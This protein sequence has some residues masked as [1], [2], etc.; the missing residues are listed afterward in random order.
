MAG[1]AEKVRA[2]PRHSQIAQ[3]LGTEIRSGIWPVGGTLPAEPEL[4][5]R[6]DVSRMTVRQ[7]LGTLAEQGL[8]I[9]QRGRPTRIAYE[10]F[11]QPLGRFYSFAYEV[12][13]QGQVHS[14]RVLERGLT[15]PTALLREAFGMGN[16]EQVAQLSLLRLLGDEPLM[17]ET[18]NFRATLLPLIDRSDVTERA[19]YDILDEAGVVVTR[20]SERIWPI[21]LTSAQ[22]RLLAAPARSSAFLVRRTSYVRDVAVE[23]RESVVRGDRYYF[24]A[25]LR[26][27]QIPTLS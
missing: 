8:L 13:R 14:S 19:I 16:G 12:E 11:V 15:R 7:A 17:I 18:I 20:A 21:A 4:A 9:R 3:E 25:E 6:F 2:I 10:P 27:D 22:A 24:V 5:R 1:T 26:R 23:V